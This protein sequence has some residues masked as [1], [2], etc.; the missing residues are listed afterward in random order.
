MPRESNN[1]IA[2]WFGHRIH[3]TVLATSGSIADQ[4]TQ[5]CPFL[6]EVKGRHEPCVKNQQ[7]RGV[8]TVSAK[9]NGARQDWVVCP[10]RVFDPALINAVAAR[11]FNVTDKNRLRTF[12]APTLAE[13]EVQASILTHLRSDGIALVYFRAGIGGEVSLARTSNSPEMAFNVTFVELLIEGTG[14]KLGRFGILELQ[15]MDFHG[16]YREAVSQ[17]R[18]SVDLFPDDF[19][20]QIKAHPE[21]ASEE[22]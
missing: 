11:L 16:S 21:W 4:R 14:I 3:P 6:S 12:A 10:F 19:P 7:S 17:L 15:T 20:E 5:R 1:S 9:S 18:K 2:E 22:Q 13:A 8:C